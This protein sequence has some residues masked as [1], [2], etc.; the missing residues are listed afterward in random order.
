[1]S[2]HKKDVMENNKLERSVRQNA[3]RLRDATKIINQLDKMI[4]S[5]YLKA[6]DNAKILL[7][8][9]NEYDTIVKNLKKSLENW[10]EYERSENLPRNFTFYKLYTKFFSSENAKP[11]GNTN[12]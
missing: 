6:E 12:V 9:T 11:K 2:I 8:I 7:Q 3:A 4:T 5:D 1:M 10:F